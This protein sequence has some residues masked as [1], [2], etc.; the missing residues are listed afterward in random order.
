MF[1][2]MQSDVH[3]HNSCVLKNVFKMHGHVKPQGNGC[4]WEGKKGRGL[5][6]GKWYPVDVNCNKLLQKALK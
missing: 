4:F 6:M 2:N 3:I 5:Q 1:K